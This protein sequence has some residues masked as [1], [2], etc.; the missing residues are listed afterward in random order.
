MS[1]PTVLIAE[2][3]RGLAR[4][5]S[6]KLRTTGMLPTVCRD[7]AEAWAA[8]VSQRPMAIV[9]DYQMPGLNGLELA[10]RVREV[11]SAEELP[12]VLVTGR[13][14]DLDATALRSSLGISAVLAK[15]FSPTEL[16]EL[17]RNL[18]AAA[19]VA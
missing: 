15:P 3:N 6:F 18:I 9:S 4:V 14:T 19:A 2:D 7:G 10:E 8:F 5:L 17:L 13:E 12:F 1:Y 16:C 11:A